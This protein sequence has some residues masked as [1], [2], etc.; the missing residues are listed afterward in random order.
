MTTAARVVVL[1]VR[2]GPLEIHE[3]ALPDP[4]PH[5]VV[6]RQFATGVCHSQL[7]QMHA[8]RHAPVVLGHEST[9]VVVQAGSEVTHVAEGDEVLVTWVPRTMAPG[10]PTAVAATLALED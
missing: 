9:G 2:K 8:E 6:V 7:H 5:Q 10:A 1:P 3:V 4:G